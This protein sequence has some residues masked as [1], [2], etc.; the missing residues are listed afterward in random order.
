MTA[1]LETQDD[2]A[3]LTLG[4]DENRFSPEWLDTVDAHL[5]DVEANAR[6]LITVGQGKFYSNGLDLDW[7]RPTQIVRIGTW[8]GC[9][10]CSPVF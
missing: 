8:A 5:D 3:V 10:T 2:I 6:G 9:R 4:D 7:L 1:T